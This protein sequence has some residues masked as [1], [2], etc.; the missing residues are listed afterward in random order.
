[1]NIMDKMK[2]EKKRIIEEIEEYYDDKKNEI[3]NKLEK[4]ENEKM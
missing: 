3:E 4:Y 2:K 1:M